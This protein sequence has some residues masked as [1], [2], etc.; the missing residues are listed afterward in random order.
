MRGNEIVSELELVPSAA[1]LVFEKDVVCKECSPAVTALIANFMSRGRPADTLVAAVN[2]LI[3][4]P[5]A[6][7]ISVHVTG[8]DQ[9][10]VVCY[11]TGDVP[12]IDGLKNTKRSK[13]IFEGLNISEISHGKT[14]LSFIQV[15]GYW[16]ATLT[17]FLVEDVVRTYADPANRFSQ[18][19]TGKQHPALIK[20]DA[21]NLFLNLQ[22]LPDLISVF[23]DESLATSWFAPGAITALDVKNDAR[24]LTMNGFTADTSKAVPSLHSIV[25]QQG[26]N[27][28]RLKELISNRAIITQLLAVSDGEALRKAL[29]EMGTT[30]RGDKDSIQVLAEKFN[31]PMAQLFKSLHG[32]LA[33]AYFES[34]RSGDSRKI[35]ILQTKAPDVWKNFLSRLESELSEDSVFAESF[36]NYELHEVPLNKFVEKL[37]SPLVRG[38]ESTYYTISGENI[39]FADD[40][41]ELKAFLRDIE[42]DE[43]ISRSTLHNKMLEATL[44]ESTLSLYINVGKTFP[45]L[46]SQAKPKWKNVFRE[47]ASL[48]KAIDF[49]SV[50]VSNLNSTIYTNLYL[51]ERELSNQRTEQRIVVTLPNS[52]R[53]LHV[54]R[55]HVNRKEEVL[56]Q[57]SVNNLS[58]VSSDGSVLWTVPLGEP[59]TSEISQIDF[60]K[61]GKLQYFFATKSKLHILDRNGETVDPFPVDLFAADIQYA[62]VVDYDNSKNYRFLITERNGRVWI[63]DKSGKSLDGWNPKVMDV[64]LMTP[65]RHQRLHGKDY[66]IIAQP[67]GHVFLFNRRGER[68]RNFPVKV[69]GKINGEFFIEA[70]NKASGTVINVVT[71]DGF[72]QRINLSGQLTAREPLLRSAITNRFYLLNDHRTKSYVIVQKDARNIT[73][74][75]SE[76]RTLITNNLV[77]GNDCLVD[78][79]DTGSGNYFALIKD[80][81][82]GMNYVYASSSEPISDI[83][84]E[85]MLIKLGFANEAQ[86]KIYYVIKGNQ[87][88]IEEIAPGL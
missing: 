86:P 56:V 73:V 70:A 3:Q 74:L 47:N 9:F 60:F 83:P 24:S 84:Y 34:Q 85:A 75:D 1:V 58:L 49:A 57:D 21:G 44:L 22:K 31:Q 76:G 5:E 2:K 25:N 26:A 87:L 54:V 20:G 71:N 23:V 45:L 61:N 13:R 77:N 18:N 62:S 72:L 67:D 41:G 63:L 82:Q 51:H 69:S 14:K 68:E 59:V 30:S 19:V 81:V 17:P 48:I 36:S 33:L 39:I 88:V 38:F 8:N 16:A 78:Y 46:Q 42:E 12:L 32:E 4:S 52:L 7:F 53:S 15:Q 50:Q 11:G 64:S 40:L 55:S 80:T 43:T 66:F 27:P 65:P 79:F 10:D 6:R 28:Y 29:K 37:F 35:F